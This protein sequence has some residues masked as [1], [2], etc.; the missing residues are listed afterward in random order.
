MQNDRITKRPANR[1]EFLDA[2]R[3]ANPGDCVRVPDGLP[4]KQA[5]AAANYTRPLGVGVSTRYDVM[6]DA[7][8]ITF[9]GDTSKPEQAMAQVFVANEHEALERDAA[10]PSFHGMPFTHEEAAAATEEAVARAIEPV[11]MTEFERKWVDTYGMPS[12]SGLPVQVEP[13][14]ISGLSPGA[15]SRMAYP[16]TTGKLLGRV[17][18]DRAVRQV[19]NLLTEV[20]AMATRE[21]TAEDSIVDIVSMSKPVFEAAA[22]LQAMLAGDGTPGS[23]QRP[24]S[25]EVVSDESL[26]AKALVEAMARE[27]NIAQDIAENIAKLPDITQEQAIEYND[28][29]AIQREEVLHAFDEGK[30]MGKVEADAKNAGPYLDLQLELA[31][32]Q[33]S[34]RVTVGLAL[35]GWGSFAALLIGVLH[36]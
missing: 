22:T 34:N 6:T 20:E 29:A 31:A 24:Q 19:H 3:N 32:A 9:G 23:D 25:M 13:R 8:L 17:L 15:E 30:A 5:L 1:D 12:I 11:P 4:L 35:L 36:G 2:C 14:S 27:T 10:L 26:H 7:D 16:T 33:R 18:G 28:R 21:F